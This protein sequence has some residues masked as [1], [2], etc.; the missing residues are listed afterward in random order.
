MPLYKDR[1][2]NILTLIAVPFFIMGLMV[3]LLLAG[4]IGNFDIYKHPISDLGSINCSPLPFFMNGTFIVSPIILSFFFFKLFTVVDKSVKDSVS[5]YKR[6]YQFSSGLGFFLIGI[7]L[8]SLFITGL[9]N[10]D[11]SRDLHNIC[12][13][14][15][16]IPLIFGELIIGSI[17]IILDIVEKWISILMAFGHLSVSLLYFF[18]HTVLLEWFFFLILLSWALPLSLKISKF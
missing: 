2:L 3:S 17:L 7:M 1:L 8:I 11:L 4:L 18:I 10:V 12:T 5:K 15:V 16:F 9:I 13:M 14:F 6:L